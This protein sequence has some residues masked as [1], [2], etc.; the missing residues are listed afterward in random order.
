MAFQK[1]NLAG[2]VFGR[3]TVVSY[4]GRSKWLC[5]CSCGTQKNVVSTDLVKGKTSSCGC[6]QREL[7]S[8]ARKLL[9]LPGSIIQTP[10]GELT[11]IEEK[12]Q[13]KQF[14]MFKL[15]CYCGNTFETRLNSLRTGTTKSCGCLAKLVSSTNKRTHGMTGSLVYRRWQAMITRATNPNIKSAHSYSGRGITVCD[16]WRVFE[17]FLEDMGGISDPALTLDRID[18][19]GDY[20]KENCRWVTMEEQSRNKRRGDHVSGVRQLPS[21]NY[22]VLI[23]AY[24]QYTKHIG[25]YPTLEEA[26]AAR[27]EAEKTYWSIPNE[28]TD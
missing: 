20:C 14:R 4:S 26:K 6:L 18:N 8:S 17:N 25:V 24:P 5:N 2:S 21:G 10:H 19:D 1:H 7:L 3:L 27:L 15:R 9:V 16:R 11:V 23:N 12:P 13:I 22:R 28:K